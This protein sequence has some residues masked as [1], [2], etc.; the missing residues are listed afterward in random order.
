MDS[1][2]SINLTL[3]TA[4]TE[5]NLHSAA[6]QSGLS[7]SLTEK[8]TRVAWVIFTTILYY[9]TFMYFDIRPDTV[10]AF[11]SCWGTDNQ[12]FV[13]YDEL[14]P[15]SELESF[16][17]VQLRKLDN[18]QLNLRSKSPEEEDQDSL[19]AKIESVY[20]V[21]EEVKDEIL[22]VFIAILRKAYM[23]G[24]RPLEVKLGAGK[25]GATVMT[26][27]A[28]RYRSVDELPKLSDLGYAEKG[29]SVV[30]WKRVD[31][32]FEIN[33]VADWGMGSDYARILELEVLGGQIGACSLNL[34]EDRVKLASYALTLQDE[35][36]TTIP[37][38]SAFIEGLH[39]LINAKIAMINAA[40][41]A[42]RF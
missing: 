9:L 7:E 25:N 33:V 6:E 4:A 22:A 41:E 23:R 38:A 32:H 37:G 40:V 34:A 18:S 17:N 3:F 28:H 1:L 12:G 30:P 8:V 10:G 42:D 19:S 26:I 35:T 5:T 24:A 11:S 14:P 16:L 21:H 31:D 36:F 15:D 27:A 13:T 20:L 39:E 29:V 2:P